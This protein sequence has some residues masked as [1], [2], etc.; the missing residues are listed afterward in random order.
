MEL[1]YLLPYNLL[2]SLNNLWIVKYRSIIFCQVRIY[3]IHTKKK[4][5]YIPY[6]RTICIISC[7]FWNRDHFQIFLLNYE[8]SPIYIFR[9][10]CELILH[11]L[12]VIGFLGQTRLTCCIL[13][14]VAKVSSLFSHLYSYI[15][16]C[17]GPSCLLCGL[18]HLWLPSSGITLCCPTQASTAVASPL[19]EHRLWGVP[20]SVVGHTGSVFVILKRRS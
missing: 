12:P 15:F 16:G 18:F 11:K 9:L 13:K 10:L 4:D 19:A 5:S 2:F 8:Y 7:L 14:P 1:P 3:K 17:A 6:V 20:A